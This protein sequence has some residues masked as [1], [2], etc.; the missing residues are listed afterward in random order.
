MKSDYSYGHQIIIVTAAIKAGFTLIQTTAP[1]NLNHNNRP[2]KK[3]KESF[4][5]IAGVRGILAAMLVAHE[6]VKS[7]TLSLQK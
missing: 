7:G 2:S 6:I 1:L 5:S 4:P 3:F